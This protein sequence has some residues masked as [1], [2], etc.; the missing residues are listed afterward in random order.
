[1]YVVFALECLIGGIQLRPFT[2]GKGG[3]LKMN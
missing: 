2:C 3:E 1:M